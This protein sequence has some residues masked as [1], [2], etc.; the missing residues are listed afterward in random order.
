MPSFKRFISERLECL[1]THPEV[2]RLTPV[3]QP[4]SV[5]KGLLANKRMEVVAKMGR[6][7]ELHK[8]VLYLASDELVPFGSVQ[9]SRNGTTYRG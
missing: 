1:L 5:P 3:I 2:D 7:A 9:M 4:V 6:E 8:T